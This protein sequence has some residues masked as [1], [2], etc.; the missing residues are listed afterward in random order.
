M[1][2]EVKNLSFHYH[3]SR[4]VFENVSFGLEQGEIMSI[5]GTNG[6]GKSTL[7]NCV[8]N[9]FKPQTGEIL[10]KGKSIK[11]MSL[12]EIA[13][14]IGY[15]PQTHNA[16][17]AYTVLEF[18]VMGRTPHIGFLASPSAKDYKI[19]EEALDRMR[20]LHLKDKAY[21]E[22]SGGER[23]QVL[24]AR[25][26]TQQPDLILLDEPTSHLDYGNQFRTVGMIKELSEQ[27]FGIIMT[28][29]MPD[30]AIILDG[31]VGVLDNEGHLTVGT[32]EDIM[33]A[34]RLTSLYNLSIKTQFS[35]IAGRRICIACPDNGYGKSF[36]TFNVVEGRLQEEQEICHN[37]QNT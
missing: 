10:L 4:T 11:D 17:Y 7:L 6:A 15:V 21:T 27:G 30:Q 18:T 20:V 36:P 12:R 25:V 16:V 37:T 9:L 8:A 28:T 34:E 33:T 1:I 31:K 29:H 26:L 13:K 14:I 19:A 5:I 35:D 3:N 24:L 23:Q 22:I 2:M 32:A